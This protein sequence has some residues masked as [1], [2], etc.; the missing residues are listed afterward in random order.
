MH[1]LKRRIPLVVCTIAASVGLFLGSTTIASATVGSTYTP[2]NIACWIGSPVNAAQA[3]SFGVTVN[4]TLVNPAPGTNVYT[5]N[6]DPQTVPGSVASFTNIQYDIQYNPATLNPATPG[7]VSYSGGYGIT[8]TP[9][10][11]ATTSTNSGIPILRMT[12]PRVNPGTFAPPTIAVKTTSSS[13]DLNLNTSSF[14]ESEFGYFPGN[15]YRYTYNGLPF[16][17]PFSANSSCIPSN[18]VPAS[19][20]SSPVLNAGAGPLH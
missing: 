16:P 10:L 4:H 17:F 3:Q 18:T 11:V 8:G 14:R 19:P 2:F 20:G 1:A 15:F 5:I 9:T 7:N 13:F 12:V 6:F